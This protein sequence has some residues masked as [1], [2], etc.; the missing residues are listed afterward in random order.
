MVYN[1]KNNYID[2]KRIYTNTNNEQVIRMIDCEIN[3]TVQYPQS[4][5]Q[6]NTY[7]RKGQKEKGTQLEWYHEKF[8]TNRRFIILHIHE[9]KMDSIEEKFNGNILTLFRIS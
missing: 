7:N 6:I 5:W 4:S 3:R 2:D 8:D 9:E 1:N